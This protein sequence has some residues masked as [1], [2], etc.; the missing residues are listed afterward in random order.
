MMQ[1][2]HTVLANN[3]LTPE[4]SEPEAWLAL[5]CF[6]MGRLISDSGAKDNNN[7]N[8]HKRAMSLF[9]LSLVK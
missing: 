7:D 3:K 1:S 2:T 8:N 5:F 6:V 4:R 9:W